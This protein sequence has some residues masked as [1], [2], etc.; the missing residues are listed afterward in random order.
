MNNAT[1]YRIKSEQTSG[2]FYKADN[3]PENGNYLS[4]LIR[5][6]KNGL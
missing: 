4:F 2:N 5:P 3:I 6:I 1:A